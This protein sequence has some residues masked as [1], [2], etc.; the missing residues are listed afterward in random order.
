M[1]LLHKIAHN[2]NPRVLK[3]VP[4]TNLGTFSSEVN[5]YR[6]GWDLTS[7]R[8]VSPD[9][10]PK[11]NGAVEETAQI[12]PRRSSSSKR[13]QEYVTKTAVMKFEVGYTY[14]FRGIEKSDTGDFYKNEPPNG[15]R[16]AKEVLFIEEN[17]VFKRLRICRL[18]KL[19][20]HVP[21][22]E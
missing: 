22:T 1:S 15:L 10:P 2:T 19:G 8:R 6:K 9:D 11:S 20:E 14:S 3:N 21:V 7:S 16:G 5:L 13:L 12:L 4:H 17:S 18:E